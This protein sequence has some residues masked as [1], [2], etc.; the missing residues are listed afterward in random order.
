MAW[1][2]WQNAGQVCVAPDYVMVHEEV[3]DS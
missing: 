3:K 2:K 1:G